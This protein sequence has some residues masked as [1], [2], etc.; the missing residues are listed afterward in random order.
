MWNEI[1]FSFPEQLFCLTF[2]AVLGCSEPQAAVPDAGDTASDTETVVDICEAGSGFVNCT[3]SWCRIEPGTFTLG[4]P[5]TEP[6]RGAYTETQVEVTLTRPFLMLQH[7]VTQTEWE[8]AGLTNPSPDLAPDKPVSTVNWYEALAYCNALSA[9][10]GLEECYN[11][12]DCQGTIGAGCE[13]ESCPDLFV[14]AGE[15]HRFDDWYACPGYRLPT[16]AE[17]EY[18]A[19]AGTTTST[20]NGDVTTGSD[21]CQVDAVVESIAWYCANSGEEPSL[22]RVCEKQPNAWGLF[23]VSGNVSEWIDYVYTGFDLEWGE[24]KDGP[25]TDPQGADVAQDDRRSTKGGHYRRVACYLRV[26]SHSGLPDWASQGGTGF[27][28]VRTLFD[29]F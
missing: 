10:E 11:L 23:D 22:Q 20:Y 9:S 28:P 6:C 24:G 2:T 7:E 27:R 17:W 8:A 1:M 25:L 14:C 12:S 5:I 18:A 26:A 21:S 13:A 3:D 16:S 19:R 4:S 29:D 15:P